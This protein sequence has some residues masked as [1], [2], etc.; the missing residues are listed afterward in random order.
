MRV[1]LSRIRLGERPNSNRNA[2]PHAGH[3]KTKLDVPNGMLTTVRI[4]TELDVLSRIRL[5]EPHNSNRSVTPHAGLSKIKL[6]E[7]N[8]PPTTARI[9]TE[10]VVLSKT[11]LAEPLNKNR[12]ATLHEG[13]NR[14]KRAAPNKPPTIARIRIVPVVLNRIRLAE[15]RNR[16]R[17]ATLQERPSKIKLGVA[18]KPQRIEPDK[19][20]LVAL[21]KKHSRIDRVSKLLNVPNNSKLN[22]M[23]PAKLSRKPPNDLKRARK[24]LLNRVDRADCETG[25]QRKNNFDTLPYLSV[26]CC[27]CSSSSRRSIY[28]F[29][30]CK[31]GTCNLSAR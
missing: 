15:P 11:K 2:T 19:T 30:T 28:R 4:R 7:P 21:S 29:G 24:I 27:S 14:I 20:R 26:C 6:A 12:N 31:S 1:V 9:R 17:N 23:L 3:S 8:K 5:V 25:R 22:E 16:N 10:P 13:L 18:S